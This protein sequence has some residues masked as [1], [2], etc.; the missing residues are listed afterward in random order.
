MC[1]DAQSQIE[2]LERSAPVL[3]RLP[4][5]PERRTHDYLRN[6]TTNLYAAL[7]VASGQ[8]IADTSARHRAAQFRRFPEPDRRLGGGPARRPRRARRLVDPQDPLDRTSAAAPAAL[9]A[10]L[11]AHL[12][13]LAQ[14]GR[15]LV[16]ELTT[17]WSLASYC[18]RINDS[19]H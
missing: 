7:E 9:H 2:A 8:A 1:V 10:P 18:Q 12:Q 5:V 4:G 6:A 14:A 13:L 17:Q 15:A 3:A 19:G 11:H 16:A